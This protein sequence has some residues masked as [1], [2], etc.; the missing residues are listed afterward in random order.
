MKKAL[1]IVLSA[2]LALCLFACAGGGDASSTKKPEGGT[3]PTE[4]I[5]NGKTAAPG[6]DDPAATDEPGPGDTAPTQENKEPVAGS[7]GL[8][9]TVDDGEYIITGIGDCTLTDIV[10]KVS[11]FKI[12][13]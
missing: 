3:K 9:G 5:D 4:V 12:D 2:M 10:S 7:E 6:E 13:L 1:V 11:T 8:S